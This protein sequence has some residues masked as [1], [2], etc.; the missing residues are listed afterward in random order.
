MIDIKPQQINN[1]TKLAARRL[2][3]AVQK[4]FIAYTFLAGVIIPIHHD[5]N[6]AETLETRLGVFSHFKP[7]LP[8]KFVDAQYVF[9]ANIDPRL[10][11]DEHRHLLRLSRQQAGTRAGQ[12]LRR[13]D[14]VL[15]DLQ[16]SLAAFEPK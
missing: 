11:L 14:E 3:G 4:G 15:D 10:Q 7:K 6:S 13:L 9:L 8:E 12:A 1:S 16:R 5:L 2:V